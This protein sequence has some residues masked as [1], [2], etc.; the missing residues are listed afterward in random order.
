[1]ALTTG[2]SKICG[3]RSGGIVNLWLVDKDD[4][5]QTTGFTLAGGVYTAVTMVSGKVFFK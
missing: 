1:M 3:A 2:Y 5:N 4:V